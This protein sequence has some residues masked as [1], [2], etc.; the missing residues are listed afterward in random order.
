MASQNVFTVKWPKC[1]GYQAQSLSGVHVETNVQRQVALHFY[2]EI[3]E[4]EEEVQY[5]GEGAR[6]SEPRTVTYVRELVGTMLI[7]ES[8]ALQLRDMLLALFP[9]VSHEKGLPG[10]KAN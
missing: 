9:P 2:N 6:A 8:A 7:G 1:S 10:G 3:R 5:T 4:L